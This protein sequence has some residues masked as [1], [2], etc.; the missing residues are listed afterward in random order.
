VAQLLLAAAPFSCALE[1]LLFA[2]CISVFLMLCS[3]CKMG[4]VTH[5]TLPFCRT[6][7]LLYLFQFPRGRRHHYQLHRRD[8]RRRCH[9]RPRLVVAVVIVI[10]SSSSP[11]T[12]GTFL[13]SYCGQSLLLTATFLRLIVVVIVAVTIEI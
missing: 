13:V 5:S 6:P 11:S 1:T 9:R 7:F 10:S 2:G 4:R 3:K 12:S 8:G